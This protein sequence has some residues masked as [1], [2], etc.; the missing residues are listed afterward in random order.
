MKRQRR[1]IC[2]LLLALACFQSP[3]EAIQKGDE[4]P[5][6]KLPNGTVLNDARVLFV[7]HAG[8]IVRHEDGIETVPLEVFGMESAPSRPPVERKPPPEKAIEPEPVMPVVEAPPPPAEAFP[9]SL[10]PLTREAFQPSVP[11][12]VVEEEPEPPS[13]PPSIPLLKVPVP[14]REPMP[15]PEPVDEPG[16]LY[17]A[18]KQAVTAKGP[19]GFRNSKWGMSQEEVAASEKIELEESIPGMLMGYAMVADLDAAVGYI[20][21]EGKLVGGKYLFLE[22]HIRN[23]NEFLSDH[24]ILKEFLTEKYGPPLTNNVYWSNESYK[25]DRSQWGQALVA[26]HLKIISGW[27][28]LDTSVSLTLEGGNDNADLLIEYRQKKHHTSISFDVD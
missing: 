19:K 28:S 20:L 6:L 8:I 14:E 21:S 5:V 1:W 2:L 17:A 11:S 16:D 22:K 26:G 23:R 18:L 13:P 3:G 4:F 15:P 9:S 27:E 12:I 7:A 10:E 25:S 24:A